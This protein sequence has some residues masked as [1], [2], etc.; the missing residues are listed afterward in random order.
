M[1]EIK[2]QKFKIQLCFLLLLLISQSIYSQPFENDYYRLTTQWQ[3]EGKSLDVINDG[4]NNKLQLAATDNLSGQA[5]KITAVGNGYYRLTTKWLGESKSLDVV[6]DGTNNKLKLAETKNASGQFWKITPVGDGYYRLTTKW[7]G[8]EKSLDIVNDGTND[9]LKLANTSNVSGQ[10][11]KITN[12]SPKTENTDPASENVKDFKEMSVSGFRIMVNPN[13][14]GKETTNQ[15]LEILADRLELIK[16]VLKPTHLQKLKKV[17]FWIEGKKTNGGMVYHPSKDW[18]I[19]NGYPAQMAK[20]I[21]INNVRHFIDWQG[22][23]PFMVLHELAHAYDDLVLT[24]MQDKIILAYQTAVSSRKYDN[25]AH[26]NG[27]KQRHY[28]LTNKSEY[29]A[30]LTEAYFGKND[31]YPF[32]KNQLKE[33]DPIGYRLMQKAWK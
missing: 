6:N 18:L 32:T 23:Q 31:L 1:A 22:D 4:T 20:S 15:A 27:S 14:V 33:F 10:L 12:L 16:T 2:N 28:G 3:G 13:L 19:N 8:E 11:W 21:E 26:I 7:L 24:A 29:F 30:E 17:A 9:K 25:V 5:W